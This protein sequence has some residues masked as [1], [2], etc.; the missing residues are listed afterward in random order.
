MSPRVLGP[1]SIVLLS[2]ML[3]LGAC[4]RR[5]PHEAPVISPRA[6]TQAATDDEPAAPL[7]LL[8]GAAKVDITPIAGVPLGGHAI[9]GGI[10][11]GLWTR[12]WARAIY[13]EDAAGEPLV[14]VIADLWAMPAGLADDVVERVREHHGLKQLGRAQVLIAA[15]HTH[16]SPSN[17]T[18][19]RLYNRGASNTM[20]YDPEL[21]DFLARRLAQAIAEA[22]GAAQPARLR[23][24]SATIPGVARNRSLPPFL[25]NPEAAGVLATN[26]DLETCPDYPREVEGVDPCQAVDPTLTTLRIEDLEGRALAVAAFF[27]AHPTTM[28]N[29]TDAYNGD[30]FAIATAAAEA[31][32]AATSAEAGGPTI[33]DPVVALFNGPQGD[34][35]PNWEEQGPPAARELGARL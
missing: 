27:A 29:L 13:I 25:E 31:R 28:V 11:Y 12:L 4:A 33:A 14:L 17:Y 9:E 8:A 6:D 30:F 16:H 22:A 10:G 3:A 35:S 18:S 26:A 32:L 21:R 5:Q 20:G 19:S 2:S 23:L 15:T 1:L 7:P 34:I 24:E